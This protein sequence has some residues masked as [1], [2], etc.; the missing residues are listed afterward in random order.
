[1]G[2]YD[3]VLIYSQ[4]KTLN[5]GIDF[6]DE[7]IVSTRRDWRNTSIEKSQL[8]MF[9]QT[10]KRYGDH[11]FLDKIKTNLKILGLIPKY[12]QV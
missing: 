5:V 1:L 3:D 2:E 7:F 9:A 11:I 12:F 8:I 6:V 10:N 4:I